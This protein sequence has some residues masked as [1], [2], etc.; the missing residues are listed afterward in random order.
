MLSGAF[1]QRLKVCTPELAGIHCQRTIK[2]NVRQVISC[3]TVSTGGA[4][5]TDGAPKNASEFQRARAK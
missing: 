5:K 1:C 3:Q 2:H 4:V